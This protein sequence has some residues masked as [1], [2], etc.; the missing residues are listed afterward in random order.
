M[1]L[2]YQS[3]KWPCEVNLAAIGAYPLDAAIRFGHSDHPDA[4][5]GGGAGRIL[6]TGE[7][8]RFANGSIPAADIEGAEGAGFLKQDLGM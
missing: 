3:G 4:H 1:G 5:F 6:K 7:G 8:P 2:C